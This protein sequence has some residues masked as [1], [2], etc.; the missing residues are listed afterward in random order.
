VG[1]PAS[2]FL[3]LEIGNKSKNTDKP[4][5]NADKQLKIADNLLESADRQSKTADRA[6][7]R[8]ETESNR[9]FDIR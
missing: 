1:D 4:P 6:L 3:M 7:Y 9:M 2:S 5:K 8:I